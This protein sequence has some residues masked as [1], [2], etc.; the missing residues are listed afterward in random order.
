MLKRFI[1]LCTL[2]LAASCARP[3]TVKFHLEG[4]V[5]GARDSIIAVAPYG[6]DIRFDDYIQVK[7][8]DKKIDTVLN[9]NPD[10]V[11]QLY[12]P[13]VEGFAAC[14]VKPLFAD[15]DGAVVRFNYTSSEDGS[16]S[17]ADGNLEID[18]SSKEAKTYEQLTG[19]IREIFKS[20]M[21][22]LMERQDSLFMTGAMMTPHYND[23]I[24][25]SSDNS[26][27]QEERDA[28]RL[29]INKLSLSGESRTEE[30]KA[31]Y[32]EFEALMAE[33]SDST[34][35]HLKAQK[36]SLAAFLYLAREIKS[37]KAPEALISLYKERYENLFPGCNL[38]EYVADAIAEKTIYVGSSFK[39][40][41]LPDTEGNQRSLSSLIEGKVAVVE[42]WASWCGSCR[43]NCR[44]MIPVYEKYKDSGFTFVGVAREYDDDKD[45]REAISEDG[46]PWVNLIA[47]KENHEIWSWYGAP[48]AAG[49]SYLVGKDGTI[50]KTNPSPQDVE[51]AMQQQ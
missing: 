5:E 46:Y 23:L 17:A 47:F 40:F 48:N 42:L 6:A 12:V 32:Q 7:I 28:I 15:A 34:L 33:R 30:G 20:R 4:S 35:T 41:A 14:M 31:W 11:Y 19:D 9:L 39:D 10:T 22:P 45:W 49:I 38:H 27:S 16:F 25:R 8:A 24:H 1:W 29:E 37:S 50:L 36:P 2:A 26:L 21:D 51:E 43:A 18:T 3:D 44:S 13:L